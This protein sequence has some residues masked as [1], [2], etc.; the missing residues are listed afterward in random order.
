MSTTSLLRKLQKEYPLASREVL[1]DILVSCNGDVDSAKEL[2]G[3]S[4][5][6]TKDTTSTRPIDSPKRQAS[7]AIF[8]VKKRKKESE[9]NTTCSSSPNTLKPL[10]LY[11]PEDIE[12]ALPC[13]LIYNVLEKAEAENLLDQLMEDHNS[14]KEKTKFYLFD[15]LCETPTS[16]PFTLK[17]CPCTRNTLI[18]TMESLSTLPES[19][20][21]P[22]RRVQIEFRS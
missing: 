11:T 6:P 2:L 1:L 21:R 22:W 7:I 13:S 17:T 15:K 18:D 9:A 12:A 3:Q 5:T 10:T 4:Q 16:L 8:G 14:W 20:A 19:T